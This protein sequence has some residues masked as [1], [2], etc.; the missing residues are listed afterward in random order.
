MRAFRKR[1]LVLCACLGWIP[2]LA[3]AASG[4]WRA[5][6]AFT[7][8]LLIVSADFLWLTWSFGTLFRSGRPARATAVRGMA[9]LFLRMILLLLGLYGTLRIFPRELLGVC[10]GIGVPLVLFASAGVPTKRG[11]GWAR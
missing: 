6:G 3:F 5:A 9:G 11:D 2:A 8:V 7:L 4:R 1:F 10:V